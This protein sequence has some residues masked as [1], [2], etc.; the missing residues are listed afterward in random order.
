MFLPFNNSVLSI[1]LNEYPVS[2]LWMFCS[3]R[4]WLFWNPYFSFY[5]LYFCLDGQSMVLLWA[6]VSTRC[7]DYPICQTWICWLPVDAHFYNGVI[8]ISN[9]VLPQTAATTLYMRYCHKVTHTFRKLEDQKSLTLSWHSL[10]GWGREHV[11]II[12]A[13][14]GSCKGI[15]PCMAS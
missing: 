14:T 7:L 13:A 9:T 10:S 8:L 5:I 11:T 1:L 15:H 4:Y 6:Q 12:F 2:F 3:L